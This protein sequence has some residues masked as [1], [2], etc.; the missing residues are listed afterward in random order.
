MPECRAA[1]QQC[2]KRQIHSQSSA[3]VHFIIQP[4]L[5]R[6]RLTVISF[7]VQC[8]LSTQL[9]GNFHFGRTAWTLT[10]CADYLLI[11]VSAVTDCQRHNSSTIVRPQISIY[12]RNE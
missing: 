3:N 8:A 6:K 2:D 1:A 7:R 5:L 4:L 9:N 12:K 10:C 11:S